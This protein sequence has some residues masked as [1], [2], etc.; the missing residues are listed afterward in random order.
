MLGFVFIIMMMSFQTKEVLERN[1][2][3]KAEAAGTTTQAHKLPQ[4][5]APGSKYTPQ[6]VL[7]V[8]IGFTGVIDLFFLEL[9]NS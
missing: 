9:M 5:P 3:D 6:D 2:K 8:G 4:A 7:E 1:F